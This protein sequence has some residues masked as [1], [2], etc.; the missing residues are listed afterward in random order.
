MSPLTRTLTLAI[1]SAA[2]LWAQNPY[3]VTTP[4]SGISTSLA[5]NGI[6]GQV[7]ELNSLL[8][9]F[10]VS[11]L[12]QILAGDG[13]TAGLSTPAQGRFV[14]VEPC[15]VVDTRRSS[16][17]F[18][19]PALDGVSPRSFA[20]P[21]G[22]CG[23]P[24]TAQAYSLNVTVEPQGTLA[25][26]TLWPT[27]TAQP[28]VSTLNSFEGNVVANAA[29]V[30]AGQNGA[31]S[32]YATNPTDVILDINGYFDSASG[33]SFYP[34][35]PCRV[36]DTRRAAGP[37]GGPEFAVGETRDIPVPSSPCGLPA[38]AGAYSMNVTVVPNGYLGFLTTWAAEQPQPFASTLNSW[39]GQVVAN[40]AIVPAGANGATS[41]YVTNRTDVIL[42]ANG[43]FAAPGSTGA[44][45]F[46][47]VL[48]CRVADTRQ[49]D[50]GP[51]IAAGT[52]RS[53]EIPDSGC[54]IPSSAAAY[55]L[56]ITVVPDGGLSYLTAW[57]TGSPRPFVSTLNSFDGA[58]VAN[59]AIVPAGP[60]GA[61]SVYV[62]NQTDVILDINGY[63]A[64]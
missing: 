9:S 62:T 29:L 49:E 22:A 35:Q 27:G 1:A 42:D 13:W 2:G 14:P 11:D 44:L 52:A 33:D 45:T 10:S 4:D 3:N 24:A 7:S 30:P 5:A 47:P 55:S 36:E 58:I 61:V 39:T 32:V 40:A 59:A 31:V 63:F 17:P 15:R 8:V 12:G 43:Y 28:H 37:L 50:D 64:P 18:G 6:D 19:G 21:Q 48:P 41:V 56:N 25:Y 60:G 16:D 57:P 20:I 53:F 51:A 38:T 34:V 23:I 26:L 54:G 46:Y